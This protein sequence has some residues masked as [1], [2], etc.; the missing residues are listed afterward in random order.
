MALITPAQL[1]F[2]GDQAKSLSEIIF[3]KQFKNPSIELF[4]TIVEGIKAQKQI[5][6]A[7]QL[8]GLVGK[9]TSLCNM[10]NAT[11]TITMSEKFWSPKTH[12]DRLAACYTDFKDSFANYGMKNGVMEADL[13]E[14]D[15]WNYI[16][17]DLLAYKVA[18]MVLVS[19]WFGDT[20]AATVSDSPAGV[21]TAG[22]NTAYFNKIDGFWKQLFAIVA[23]D[24]D[25]KSTGLATKNGQSTFANQK[26]NSTDT[27]NKVVMNTLD[28]MAT[29]A[30]LR[31]RD[32]DSQAYIVTQSVLDQYKRELKN[33]NIAFTTERFE[34]G[35]EMV[36][37][38]GKPVYG[39][40]LWDRII[41]AYYSDGTK[42][43]LPHRA[44]LT[45]KENIQIGVD[46]IG[47]LAEFDGHFD[48]VTKMNY[49]D[50][51]VN[52]DAKVIEDELV[53]LAY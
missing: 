53:Q 11:N 51:A 38:D 23:G 17:D 5:P 16:S 25:R 45:T 35:I 1:S 48:K 19:A 22:T 52:L 9:Q 50:F 41:K 4:H 14:L 2:D 39:F 10:T 15:L 43:Y 7:S 42:Y 46:S 28:L 34:N 20:D 32:Q 49:I 24:S 44:V 27:T 29:D 6:L 21:L 37:C 33:A 47:T 31:L 18:E 30:D 3:A 40:S 12:A 13:S 8:S 36:E 26:F